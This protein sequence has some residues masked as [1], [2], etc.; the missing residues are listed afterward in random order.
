MQAFHF[1]NKDRIE[2]TVMVLILLNTLFLASEFY[3]QPGWLTKTQ[4]IGN[5]VF[6]IAFG[7]EMVY[8]LLV[9]GFIGYFSESSNI[10][11]AIIVIVSFVELF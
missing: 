10:F 1:R 5:F 7:I 3:N 6:T 9:M 8:L 11:D 2:N 4:E